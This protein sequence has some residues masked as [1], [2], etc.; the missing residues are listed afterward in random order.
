MSKKSLYQTFISRLESANSE[1]RFLE[2]AW[3]AY[4]IL[5]D[6]LLSLMRSTGGI[7]KGGN[8][9]PIHMMGPKLAELQY[10]AK[11]DAL[12]RENFEYTKLKTWTKARNDLMHAMA[13]AS[14]TIE[15]IDSAAEALATEGAALVRTYAAACR[16]LKKH[17]A[18]VAA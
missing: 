17:R 10:R 11:S 3:Y 16:R 7:G 9:K 12:L 4:A 1:R 8:G 14:M 15:Q 13:D 2:A 5:E 18:K 6:R